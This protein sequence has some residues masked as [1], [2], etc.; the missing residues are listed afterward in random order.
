MKKRKAMNRLFRK[1]ISSP[2]RTQ[3][4]LKTLLADNVY[5]S[6]DSSVLPEIVD[7]K[8]VD[9]RVRK[10]G[11]DGLF[12]MRYTDGRDFL[13]LLELKSSCDDDTAKRV[14]KYHAAIKND[15]RFSRAGD[16]Q[17]CLPILTLVVYSGQ[18][19]STAAK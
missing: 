6:I 3:A 18:A 2:E 7:G 4:V 12:R 19:D 10:I 1:L 11:C 13:A 5:E 17:Q 8:I 15:E 14:S 9:A 16:D